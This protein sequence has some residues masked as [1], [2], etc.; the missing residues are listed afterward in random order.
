LGASDGAGSLRVLAQ[1]VSVR[2]A[3]ADLR[4]ENGPEFAATAIL[5]WLS[6]AQ[7]EA[8][9]IDPGEPWQNT[10][11][12][13]FDGKFRDEY[14]SLQ[15]FRNGIESRSASTNGVDTTTRS[16]RRSN[17]SVDLGPERRR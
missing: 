10:T 17:R 1:L 16:A 12:E 2:G 11:D 15:S 3:P 5:R 8:A 4:S 7:I 13:S 14:P 9:L 6:T